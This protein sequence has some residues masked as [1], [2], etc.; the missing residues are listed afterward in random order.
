MKKATVPLVKKGWTKAIVKKVKKGETKGTVLV[1]LLNLQIHLST[2]PRRGHLGP[3]LRWGHRRLDL[4][5]QPLLVQS[6]SQNR[7]AVPEVHQAS[8]VLLI[9]ACT[10][11]NTDLF[12]SAFLAF[13]QTLQVSGC[14][15]GCGFL[16]ARSPHACLAKLRT[17]SHQTPRPSGARALRRLTMR[18]VLLTLRVVV[19]LGITHASEME[20]DVLM[21]CILNFKS[22]S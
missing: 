4:R 14:N 3:C 2:R 17:T 16:Q 21:F 20:N 18:P 9:G 5:S 13:G 7:T 12:F 10:Q 15:A 8:F 6:Q 1:A 11:F 19:F 22:V